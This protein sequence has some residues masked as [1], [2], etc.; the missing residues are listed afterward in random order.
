MNKTI[1]NPYTDRYITDGGATYKKLLRDGLTR[2]DLLKYTEDPQPIFPKQYKK[3]VKMIDLL[4]NL[5]NYLSPE[6]VF[7]LYVTNKDLRNEINKHYPNQSFITWLRQY[8][9]EQY[10]RHLDEVEKERV[11]KNEELKRQRK[12]SLE[13]RK[14]LKRRLSDENRQ[15]LADQKM[16]EE[17]ERI[18]QEILE[19]ERKARKIYEE[20]ERVRQMFKPKNS[21]ILTQLGI[22]NKTDL[23]Q[24][25]IKNHPDKGGDAEVA[26]VVIEEGQRMFG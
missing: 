8:L 4:S 6:E 17:E 15:S 22:H 13:K 9:K 7:N 10:E 21:L 24:W 11:A 1:L 2:E 3:S 25:L 16:R 12:I 23:R 20:Q 5:V 26:K 19:D 14:K 18:R